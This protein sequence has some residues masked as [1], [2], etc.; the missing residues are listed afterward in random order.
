MIEEALKSVHRH[1][2][3][4]PAEI[5]IEVEPAAAVAAAPAPAPAEAEA[6][7]PAPVPAEAPD[8]RDK[9]IEQLKAQLDFS[10]AKGRELMEKLKDGHE[11]M[12]RA[13]ADL[14]NYRKRAAKEKEE[15]QRFGAEKLLKDLLPVADN[16]DRALEHAKTSAELESF[17][18][19]VTMTRKLFDDTLGRYGVKAFSA[20]N[21]PFD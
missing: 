7:A 6:A 3:G 16:L 8:P 17:K 5:P 2:S 12:L 15:I 18:Q 10:M 20:L 13:V 21:K 14:E 19:G 4:A 11:K 9:E 1:T